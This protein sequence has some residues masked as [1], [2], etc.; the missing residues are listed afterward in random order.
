MKFKLTYNIFVTQKYLFDVRFIYGKI[1]PSL[2]YFNETIFTIVNLQNN[3]L[4][5]IFFY[6][7]L[8]PFE[9]QIMILK[10]VCESGFFSQKKITTY[11]KKSRLQFYTLINFENN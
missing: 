4:L 9:N 10:N 5:I 1:F 2:S 8:T 11:L 7:I 3:S 6:K